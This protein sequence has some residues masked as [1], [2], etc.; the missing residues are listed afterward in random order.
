[1]DFCNLLTRARRG[2]PLGGVIAALV[3][4]VGVTPLAAAQDAVAIGPG[5]VSAPAQARIVAGQGMSPFADA[6]L[7]RGG[8][9]AEVVD[10]AFALAGTPV[11]IAHEPMKRGLGMTE[12][13]LF[14]AAFPF[15]PAEPDPTTFQRSDPLYS[16]AHKVFVD[17]ASGLTAA[18]LHDLDGHSIC[19]VDGVAVPDRVLRR[20]EEHQ[21][22]VRSHR[23]AEDC[24]RS[25][26][27]GRSDFVVMDDAQLVMAARYASVPPDRFQS[28]FT[29]GASSL[30]LFAP[31][32]R[33][34]HA[35]IQA[36]NDGLERL[37]RS[38]RYDE[39]VIRHLS[40]M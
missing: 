30:Y 23:R 25:V 6:E 16:I 37:R 26:R 5:S 39:I 17:R 7:P 8:M 2:G 9:L 14:A 22:R 34:G 32:T 1:M 40:G 11:A 12:R 15:L 3:S 18:G 4:L 13:G 35:A 20:I 19:L 33:A 27:D 38:G 29:V 36:L 28:L 31:R 21:Y 24:V 10:E